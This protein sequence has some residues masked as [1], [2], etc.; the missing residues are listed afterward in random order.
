MRAVNRNDNRSG[1]SRVFDSQTQPVGLPPLPGPNSFNKRIFFFSHK[2]ASSGLRRPRPATSRPNLWPN[3][4][5][6]FSFSFLTQT[7]TQTQTTT[8]INQHCVISLAE[9][10]FLDRK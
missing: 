3:S 6:S 5:Q 10:R 1:S 8:Q 4:T 7:E 2:P 9:M